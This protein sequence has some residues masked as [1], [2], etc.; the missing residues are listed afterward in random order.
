MAVLKQISTQTIFAGGVKDAVHA[1]HVAKQAEVAADDYELIFDEQEIQALRRTQYSQES[2]YLFF[3][4]MAA[5]TEFGETSP[6]AVTA[7]DAWLAK[8]NAIK[9]T[10]A[11]PA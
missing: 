4:Y 9:E 10:Y 7:K 6:E 11:K 8:R 3:D 5:V 1:E 2:D